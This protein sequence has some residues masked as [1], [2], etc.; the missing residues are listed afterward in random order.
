[1]QFVETAALLA[2]LE[3]DDDELQ[4]LIRGMY[5]R[6]RRALAEACDTLYLK[7]RRHEYDPTEES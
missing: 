1:M 7:L 3:E 6:E 4:R 5:P 2:V